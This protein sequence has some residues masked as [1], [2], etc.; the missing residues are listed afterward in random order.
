[1]KK[2]FVKILKWVLKNLARLTI[3]R[4]KPKI[5]GITGSVGKTSTK[6]ACAT[7]LSKKFKL[8][9]SYGN[10]NNELGLPLTILGD[11]SEQDLNLVSRNTP[12]GE[13]RIQKLSFWIKV[14]LKSVFQII[15][16][17][18]NYPQVLILEYGADRPGDIRYLLNIA[19]PDIGIITAIGEIPV[20]VEFY[21]SPEEVA[22]EKSRLIMNIPAYSYVILNYD[23]DTVMN[24]KH[25]TRAHILTFG[26]N[27][28]ADVQIINFENKIENN[29][30]LGIVF[31]IKYENNVVPVRIFG[32]FGKSHA[33]A[34]ACACALGL[35]F[36]M[37]LIEIAEALESYKPEKGRANLLEGIKN[38]LIIDDSYN[39][40][41]LSM[42]N[43]LDLLKSLPAKRKIAVLGDMLEIGKYSI[44][45]H[46]NIGKI[47]GK[48]CDLLIT[49]GPR[50]KFIAEG[51][52]SNGLKQK[53]ILSFNTV[54]EAK[55]ELIKLI[56][57]G[58]LVLL[59]ASHA[60]GL[61]QLVDYLKFFEIPNSNN[62][63]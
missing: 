33:Y 60:M 44:F 6:I 28:G 47:A 62:K 37:N 10:L 22:L 56:K 63:L 1:M 38:S 61:H 18:K 3:K 14:I 8:R 50:A 25:R 51:A 15:F 7:V 54:D 21:S 26:F 43:A 40:S 32:A 39:A 46:E 52:K 49:I 41:F 2:I 31:K 55:E 42:A 13:K 24:I 34:C 11:W 19:R 36:E 4:Y 9:S 20:H 5:V 29:K 16:K 35:V 30:P 59:K 12:Q 53:N 58:D 48:V 17:N 27:D 23:D 45:A 57:P